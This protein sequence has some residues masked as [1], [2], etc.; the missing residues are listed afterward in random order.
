MSL[1][2]VIGAAFGAGLGLGWYKLAG[3]A[4]GTCPL[5]SNPFLSTLFGA[6]VGVLIA[7]SFR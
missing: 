4:T 3:C 7:T 1:R 5:S 2:I 6:L